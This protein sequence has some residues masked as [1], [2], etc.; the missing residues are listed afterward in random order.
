MKGSVFH[1]G[2][3]LKVATRAIA[4]AVNARSQLFDQCWRNERDL[5]RVG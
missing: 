2:W 4:M 1:A 3:I 5:V